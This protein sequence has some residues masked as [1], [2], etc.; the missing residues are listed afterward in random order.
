MPV[1]D[2]P[3]VVRDISGD[4][5]LGSIAGS[6]AP[7]I[8]IGSDISNIVRL[9]AFEEDTPKDTLRSKSPPRRTRPSAI[10]V[11][12]IY[13]TRKEWQEHVSMEKRDLQRAR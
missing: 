2:V 5:L 1:E 8:G 13:S 3:V 7:G 4:K 12:A 9:C 6:F 10:I 11:P